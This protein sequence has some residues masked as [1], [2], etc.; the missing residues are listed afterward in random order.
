MGDDLVL[1]LIIT[2]VFG[3][4]IFCLNRVH[5]ARCRS[6][7][8]VFRRVVTFD[9]LEAIK[10]P[11]SKKKSNQHHKIQ[12][13]GF[14]FLLPYDTI[15]IWQRGIATRRR[16]KKICCSGRDCAAAM[17]REAAWRE[18]AGQEETQREPTPIRGARTKILGS[19]SQPYMSSCSGAVLGHGLTWPLVG[20]RQRARAEAARETAPK[21]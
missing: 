5:L 15:S 13:T 6:R 16:L 1:G 7:I 10:L 21:F 2:R 4:L 9:Y 11:L 19:G 18:M 17:G 14:F 8:F 20:I 12:V 3:L